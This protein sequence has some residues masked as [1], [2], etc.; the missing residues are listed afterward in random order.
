MLANVP[1]GSIE[2]VPGCVLH[3][4]KWL[5]QADAL[6]SELSSELSPFME[7]Y[8]GYRGFP[9]LTRK[10]ARFGL[11]GTS[12]VYGGKSRPLHPYTVTLHSIANT[13]SSALSAEFNCCYVNA[14]LSGHASIPRH[15]DISSLPQLGQ[16]PI[17][18]AVSFGVTRTFQLWDAS[19]PRD[20]SRMKHVDL[21]HGD[22]CVMHGRSQLDWLHAIPKQKE[23][24]GERLS[25][26]FR[27]HNPV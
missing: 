18:A 7:T 13:L 3:A 17:I 8:R 16:E 15:S 5:P 26:T 9:D 24:V 12:Y 19:S 14:Y 21:C 23:I 27:F 11:P 4:A 6:Y 10:F 20:R 22:L 2:I 1:N 25:L